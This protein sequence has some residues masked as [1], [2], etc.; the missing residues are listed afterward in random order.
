MFPGSDNGVP[1]SIY[2][3]IDDEYTMHFGLQ[4]HPT[5]A[6]KGSKWPV[7][8]LA[9]EPGVLVDGSGPLKPE[10]KGTFFANWWSAVNPETDFHMNLEAKKTRNFTGIP[11]VRQQDAALEWSMGPIMD[12]T[13]E[14]LGTADAVIIR[15][16]RHIL[17][18]ARALEE[19]GTP[20]PGSENPELYKVRSCTSFVAPG[21]DWQEA[22]GDW[23]YARTT[24]YPVGPDSQ[25]VP[26]GNR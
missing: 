21:E 26:R 14:H 25:G 20:P 15:A 4:W 24:E 17:A 11:T 19:D 5:K 22:L 13:K 23:H 3:P 16:R 18:A 1:L 2:V 8:D 6:V 7:P 10:Q 9:D 12:R